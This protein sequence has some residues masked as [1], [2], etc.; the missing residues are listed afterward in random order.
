MKGIILAAG[1]GKRMGELTETLP[2]PLIPLINKPILQHLLE[3]LNQSGINDII[4]VVVHQKDQIISFLQSL[5]KKNLKITIKVARD[6]QKG[7][8]YSF[9][10]CMDEIQNEEFI[11]IPTDLL[12]EPSMLR[13]I[14]QRSKNKDFTLVYDDRVLTPQHTPIHISKMPGPPRILG[15]NSNLIGSESKKKSLVPIFICRI[16]FSQYV[17]LSLNV[18]NT[19]VADAIQLYL[20]DGNEAFGLKI[21]ENYWFDLDTV[22]DVLRSNEYLLHSLEQK[23]QVL[24]HLNGYNQQN[25]TL[26]PPFLIGENC[27]FQKQCKIGPNVS[28][29]DNT[30]CGMNVTI[31]NAIISANSAISNNVEIQNAIFFKKI[32][33]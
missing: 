25:V 24:T 5:K 6:F 22:Q 3:G 12:I 29:G 1:F 8:L 10:S 33:L 31:K 17:K 30:S 13:D 20:K 28:I 26:N 4:I 18:K 23:Q 19:K 9:S 15:I 7:P 32:Y 2:K 21:K 27:H 14:L 11:L 16:D